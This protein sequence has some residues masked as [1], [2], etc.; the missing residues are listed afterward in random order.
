[1]IDSMD[2]HIFYSLELF[3]DVL[4]LRFRLIRKNWAAKQYLL[5][6]KAEFLHKFFTGSSHFIGKI[7]TS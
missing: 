2:E 1:M 3:E 7:K 5:A 4:I 6:K